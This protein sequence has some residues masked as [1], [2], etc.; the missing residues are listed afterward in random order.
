M[1]ERQRTAAGPADVRRPTSGLA[2][3]G[4]FDLD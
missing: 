4:A 3:S 1:A 2:R